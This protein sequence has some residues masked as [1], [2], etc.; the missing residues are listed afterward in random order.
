MV[1]HLPHHHRHRHH[2]H[3][4]EVGETPAPEEGAREP[5]AA[6]AGGRAGRL[7][8]PRGRAP[9][10]RSGG[11]H[12]GGATVASERGARERG[13]EAAAEADLSILMEM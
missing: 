10:R 12:G 3:L 4:P 8:G 6:A 13:P 7:P 5:A 1:L 9:G 11:V 2:H